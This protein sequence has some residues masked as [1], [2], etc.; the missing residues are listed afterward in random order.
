MEVGADTR[1]IRI[2]ISDEHSLFRD[3]IRAT[4]E[5]EPQISVVG[6]AAD[7]QETIAEVDRHRP[8]IA[9]LT[10]ACVAG[11]LVV[12]KL[13]GHAEFLLVKQR[14]LSLIASSIMALNGGRSLSTTP[15]TMSVSTSK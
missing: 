1:Q 11:M 4:L 13:F 8:D 5:R 9:I 7:A 15:Q 10:A 14:L 6:A 2:V 3:A 12:T